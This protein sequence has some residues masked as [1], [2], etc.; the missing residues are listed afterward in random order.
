[1]KTLR[2]LIEGKTRK[3]AS[4]APE[5]SVLRALQIMAEHDVGALLVLDGEHLAGIFSE[6]DYARKV[7]LH[8]R[9]S[10]DTPVSAIMTRKVFCISA[11]RTIEECMAIMTEKHFRH[12][13]VLDENKKVLGII[14]I[15]DVVKEM[16]SQ[17][18]FIIGQLENYISG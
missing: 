7:I 8:D 2:Q 16:L 18:N 15:G 6:R 1:M 13:P 14:S 11:E 12:L 4:I 9:S 3:L 17:Q 10:K 5:Q